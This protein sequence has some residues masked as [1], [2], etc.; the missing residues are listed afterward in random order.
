[1]RCHEEIEKI[2]TF[3]PHRDSELRINTDIPR[4]PKTNIPI[5]H[6]ETLFMD[7][8]NKKRKT[9]EDNHYKISTPNDYTMDFLDTNYTEINYARVINQLDLET[10]DTIFKNE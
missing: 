6:I 4:P 8:S 5:S 10:F 3:N 1:M 7:F 2:V 9:P